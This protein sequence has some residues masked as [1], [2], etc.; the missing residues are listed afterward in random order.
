MY[1]FIFGQIPANISVC[2]FLNFSFHQDPSS[3]RENCRVLS[4]WHNKTTTIRK[5]KCY[6][7]PCGLD[8]PLKGVC[9]AGELC[10]GIANGRLS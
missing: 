7:K 3:T 4:N 5:Y 10:I 6:D 1:F 2:L 9:Q 8:Y